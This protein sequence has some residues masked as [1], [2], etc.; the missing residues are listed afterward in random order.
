MMILYTDASTPFGRK[1]LLA[2]LERNIPLTEE[3]VSLS[4]PGPFADANPLVQIPALRA[5]DGQVYFDLSL[6]HI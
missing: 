3:F 1:S 6:I 4:D 5:E 2:A